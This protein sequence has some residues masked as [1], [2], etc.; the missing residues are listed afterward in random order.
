MMKCA[1]FLVYH[2]LEEVIVW[3]VW[4]TELCTLPETWEYKAIFWK[5]PST[6]R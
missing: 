2:P 1:R 3:Y 6:G 5:A 4:D